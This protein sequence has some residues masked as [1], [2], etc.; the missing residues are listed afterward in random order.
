MPLSMNREVFITCA[1]T[2][3]GDTVSKS[4]HVPITPK[5][6][7]EAAVE[8]AKA[9][10]AVVHCHVRDPETGAPARRLDLYREV[11]DRI[12]S[13]DVDMVLNLTAGMGGDLIFGNVESPLPLSE[14]GTDMAGATERVAHVA[15][16]LPEICTL[17]CGTMNF[18]LGDYVMTNTPSM[19]REMARQMTALGVRPEIEAF[20]TGHLWFAKQLVEEGLIEDPVLIQLCMG[21][22]WGAP[23]D[24]NTFMAMVNNVPAN[25]TFS[26]FSIGRNALAYPAAAILAGGNV[27]VGLEDNLYIGKGQLATNGQLVEKAVGV[28]EGMGAKI[29]G[30]K[31]VREKLKLTKR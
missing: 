1:V 31:E 3:S 15:E 29:I 17:D 14:K 16:C 4:S 21:I 26:A 25:W 27:R 8:A 11:T 22:P 5:Q 30:P 10:A 9:G 28:I 2:G 23:D 13:A 19:L 18:S 24:L 20:D 6:I 12:R 7:A